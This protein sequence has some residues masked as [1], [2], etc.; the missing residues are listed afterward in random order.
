[1]AKKAE[2]VEEEFN[3]EDYSFEDS[4]NT[5]QTEVFESIDLDMEDI[6]NSVEPICATDGKYLLKITSAKASVSKSAE[7]AEESGYKA[8]KYPNQ[9]RL[10]ITYSIVGG[11]KFDPDAI[12][13]RIKDQN[14]SYLTM[15]TPSLSELAEGDYLNTV[16]VRLKK[17]CSVFKIGNETFRTLVKSLTFSR[18]DP[19]DVDALIGLTAFAHIGKQKDKQRGEINFIKSWM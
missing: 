17:F 1:M 6:E 8:P 2:V 12:Y 3:T 4:E 5:S 10:E 16:K 14:Y 15:V 18:E 19:Q 11:Q 7:E 9:P 13:K